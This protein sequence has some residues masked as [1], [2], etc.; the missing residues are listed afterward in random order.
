[1][2]EGVVT[3]YLLLIED[4]TPPEG[5]AIAGESSGGGLLCAV[6]LALLDGRHP[7][8][9]AAV[10]MSP[11]VAFESKGA[12]WQTNADKDGFVT[13]ELALQSIPVFLPTCRFR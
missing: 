9:V 13:R 2:V 8:P 5:I 1:M 12:P 10:K 7:L 4:G 6:I 11:M 3:A